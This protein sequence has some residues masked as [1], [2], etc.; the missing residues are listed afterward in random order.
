[1]KAGSEMYDV[2]VI[3]GGIN[4]VGIAA[5]AA[6]RGLKVLLCEQND[7]GSAT[8]SNSSKLI[9]G[10][11]RY[12]E[13]YEFRLVK[14]ALAEREV[15][16][17]NAPH[18]IKPLT[19]HLPHQKHL[20]PAWMIRMGLIMYDNLAT[21][22]TLPKS[23]SV[24]FG[25]DSPLKASITH[26]FSYAD[27]WVDDSRLVV[28]NAMQAK[29]NGAKIY[30]RTKC[31]AAQRQQQHWQVSLA[32]QQTGQN[33]SVK[34]KAVVNAS[35]PW[36]AKLFDDILPQTSPQNIRLVRGSHIVVPRIHTQPQA[37]ILQNEDQ[38]IV[39]VLPF[40]D[41][42][43]LVGTTD[44]DYQGDPGQVQISEQEIDYLIHL[45]NGYFNHQISR[46]DVVHTF[47]GVR[48]LI[49]DEAESAQKVSRDYRFEVDAPIT[50]NGQQAALVSVFGGKITTYRK[51]AEAAVNLLAPY[52][53]QMTQASTINCVL[54]GGDFSSADVFLMQLQA[55]Y[56]S[57]PLSLLKRWV[58]CYGT[59]TLSFIGAATS[60]S[61]LGP[62]FGHGLYAAEVNY[63]MKHEWARDA[64]D[65]LWR[66]TK[67]GL[68]FDA[69]QTR[70][71]QQYLAKHLTTGAS[72]VEGQSANR[73]TDDTVTAL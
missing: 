3:G 41:D 54:P 65:I 6:G 57:I 24:K 52:F 34:T 58:R 37:Y 9:H 62:H 8:S 30:S 72:Y 56:P 38:R 63:L 22:L 44:M 70:Q 28:L 29:Q 45:S 11:L 68:H 12:L 23:K 20:R 16:L 43:S 39:F 69:Q 73:Q 48:P 33:F 46:Q 19:F 4:G 61:Q 26:G 18:I 50:E 31:V 1:M 14:E 59:L 2:V 21:R 49:D 15:L 35:G 27:A 17:K 67:L 32:C 5:D 7:L 51:L 71:L 36:V 10:G 47:S 53:P 60:T 66:R 40:E 55:Q 42:Y 13:H 64:H 25:S